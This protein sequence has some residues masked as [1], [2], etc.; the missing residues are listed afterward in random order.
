MKSEMRSTKKKAIS[1]ADDERPDAGDQALP[2]LVEMVQKRHLR[3]G[4]FER[5]RRRSGG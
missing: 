3:A 4:V 2:E 5:R 1:A